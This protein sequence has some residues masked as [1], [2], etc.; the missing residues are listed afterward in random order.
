MTHFYAY[1]LV[2]IQNHVQ[3]VNFIIM[4][5]IC[6][7]FVVCHKWEINIW[8]I[9]KRIGSSA[10]S[11]MTTT[12]IRTTIWAQVHQ[13]AVRPNAV[14]NH[15]AILLMAHIDRSSSEIKYI[16]KKHWLADWLT[17]VCVLAAR[18]HNLPFSFSILNAICALRCVAECIQTKS[19]CSQVNIAAAIASTKRMLYVYVY[20]GSTRNDANHRSVRKVD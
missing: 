20:I 15:N 19:I 3:I 9:V 7:V 13:S 5:I 14:F 17:G 2:H 4:I 8:V 6:V 16:R 1:N 12:F 18:I 11:M 10:M